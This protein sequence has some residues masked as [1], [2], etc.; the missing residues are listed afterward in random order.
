MPGTHLPAP[1]GWPSAPPW[2]AAARPYPGRSKALLV[3]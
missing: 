3:S 2:A 1:R